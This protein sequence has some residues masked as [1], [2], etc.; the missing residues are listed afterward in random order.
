M[1]STLANEMQFTELLTRVKLL[2][3][4]AKLKKGRTAIILSSEKV[5]TEC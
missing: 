1:H 2:G 3:E 5:T 4:R